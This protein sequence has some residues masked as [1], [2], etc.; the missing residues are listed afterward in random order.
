MSKNKFSIC[1]P[2]YK[3]K[4]LQECIDS[5]LRQTVG[6]FELIILNDCSPE[7]VE[8]IS[9][10]NQDPRIRY[11]KN[12]KN[13]GAYDLVDN[14]NKC[15]ELATGEFIVIMGDDDRLATD[16][17][18]EFENLIQSYPALHVYHCRSKIIDDDGNDVLLTPALPAFEYVY[19]SIW[20]RLRQLRSNYISDYVYRTVALKS[21]GGFYKLPLAWGSDDITAFIASAKNGIAHSNKPVFEYR[22]NRLSITSTGNDLHKMMADLSYSDWLDDFLINNPPHPSEKV[23]YQHLLKEKGKYMQEKKRYTMMLSMR[24]NPLGKAKTWFSTKEKFGLSIKD[25]S[26]SLAKSMNSNR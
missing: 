12:E 13:V 6:E 25:I 15:L 1:I 20:H 4:Y 5:I 11:F 18:E 9:K 7:P 19:D 2:A 14:W 3:S 23:I 22:S 21:Q 17:L 10:K 24:S 16:Y 26:V 8:E